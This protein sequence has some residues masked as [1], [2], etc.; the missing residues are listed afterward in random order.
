MTDCLNY[1]SCDRQVFV[2][3]SQQS[4]ITDCLGTSGPPD[5]ITLEG[6]ARTLRQVKSRW[7]SQ[8]LMTRQD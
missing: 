6:W 8:V 3:I 7:K 4:P 5:K 1:L 2:H